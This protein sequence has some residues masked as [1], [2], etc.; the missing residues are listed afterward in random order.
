MTATVRCVEKVLKHNDKIVIFYSSWCSYSAA[1]MELARQHDNIEHRF[2]DIDTVPGNLN[3][4]CELFEKKKEMTGYNPNHKTRP[5]V[6]YKGKFIGGYS[7]LAQIF[8]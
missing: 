3:T 8:K 1:A 5:L 2:Y 4:L 6:F 7:E